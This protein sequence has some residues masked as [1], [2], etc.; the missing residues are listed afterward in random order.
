MVINN[1]I[2]IRNAPCDGTLK[3]FFPFR[4][5]GLYVRVTERHQKLV[6]RPLSGRRNFGLVSRPCAQLL[7]LRRSHLQTSPPP[8]TR[9]VHADR[10]V[11]RAAP[12]IVGTRPRSP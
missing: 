7:A 10:F 8:E 9:F 2:K 1:P 3:A 6:R 12:T 11:A 4:L 5:E